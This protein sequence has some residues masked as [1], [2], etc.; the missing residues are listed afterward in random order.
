MVFVPLLELEVLEN[1]KKKNKAA[2]NLTSKMENT[3]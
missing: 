2:N 3:S 1:G